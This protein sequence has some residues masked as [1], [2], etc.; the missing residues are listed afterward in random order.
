[1]R[2]ILP[3]ETSPYLLRTW[4]PV[5]RR[6]PCESGWPTS[7]RDD[8][9]AAGLLQKDVCLRCHPPC[10]C[11]VCLLAVLPSPWPVKPHHLRSTCLHPPQTVFRHRQ[12]VH[13]PLQVNHQIH[14]LRS[15]L[16]LPVSS[17]VDRHLSLDSQNHSTNFLP[18]PTPHPC[19]W[20]LTRSPRFYPTITSLRLSPTLPCHSPS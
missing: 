20:H 11:M 12:N 5:R 19:A 1:M 14:F 8:H 16:R 18:S 9:L 3:F 7:L 10:Q 15:A 13:P 6:G 2:S 4:E 17:D